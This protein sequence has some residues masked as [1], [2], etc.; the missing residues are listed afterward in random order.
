M[1]F[2]H[3][4]D[5]TKTVRSITGAI[6]STPEM[7]I[8]PVVTAFQLAHARCRMRHYF[9]TG[10]AIANGPW[11]EPLT[12]RRIEISGGEQL[13]VAVG[14]RA[15]L[16]DELTWRIEPG[17]IE[18]ELNVQL[19]HLAFWDCVD[20]ALFPHHIPTRALSAWATHV[21]DFVRRVLREDLILLEDDPARPS[22]CN[23]C[24][25]LTSRVQLETSVGTFGFDAE[26]E[27]RL[28]AAFDDPAFPALTV[29]RRFVS[30]AA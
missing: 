20:R 30:Q 22:A 7:A 23:A 13:A 12:E 19:D 2:I 24:L 11:H 29:T 9:P 18:E 1:F 3:C 21:D 17:H 6:A 5:C 14:T 10:R 26:S 15:S 27:Q 28:L 25:T 4:E 16:H 8:D